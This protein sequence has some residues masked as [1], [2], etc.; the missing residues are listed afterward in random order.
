MA[1]GNIGSSETESTCAQ[2]FATS[3][4]AGTLFP[5]PQEDSAVASDA[6]ATADRVRF[7]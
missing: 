2:S 1:A 3:G 4:D 6:G 5:P 7:S